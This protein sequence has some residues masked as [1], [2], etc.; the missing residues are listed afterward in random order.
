[1]NT[2]DVLQTLQKGF[3][4]AVGA[5]ASLVETLQ[6]PQKRTET[7]SEL[8]AELNQ[9]TQEWAEKGAVTEQEARKILEAWLSRQRSQPSSTTP[10]SP[11]SST[12]DASTPSRVDVQE[13]KDLT[14]RIVDLRTE[15]EQLRQSKGK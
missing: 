3:R 2:N 7:F 12:A 8:Q 9:R 1:M 4:I 5:T 15:L 6:D 13:L 14:D 10:S 11:T